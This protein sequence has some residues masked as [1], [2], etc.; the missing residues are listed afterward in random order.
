MEEDGELGKL[1]LA[2]MESIKNRELLSTKLDSDS[3]QRSTLGQ[4]VADKA[5]S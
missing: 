1:D 5:A 3:G 4:R 2:V